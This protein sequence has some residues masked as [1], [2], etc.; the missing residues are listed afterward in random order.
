MANSRDL[1]PIP[2]FPFPVVA[3]PGVEARA[4]HI[5]TRCANAYQFL[6]GGFGFQPEV[7]LRVLA[8]RD[9][10]QGGPPYGM[11][12]YGQASLV[13]AGENASFWRGFIPLLRTARPELVARAR[14]VYGEQIDLGSFFDL[15][16]VHELAHAF[17]SRRAERF[18]RRWLDELFANL[19]LHS[20][21]ASVE[22][23]VLPLLVAFPAAYVTVDASHFRHT[24]LDDFERLYSGM[25][26]VNYGWYQ[27]RFHVAAGRLYDTEGAESTQRFWNGSFPPEPTVA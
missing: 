11:P 18:P 26:G 19:C 21:V 24:T 20:F 13:V 27:C 16:V 22:P 17:A 4:G 8:E 14:S 1:V 15:L 25:E 3:S 12:H 7:K 9:W 2:G 5:A 23:Q 10:P 6:A